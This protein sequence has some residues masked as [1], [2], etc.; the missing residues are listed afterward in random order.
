[1]GQVYRAT[2]T[3]LGR[4]VAVSPELPRRLSACG[5]FV[6]VV[7]RPSGGPIRLAVERLHE[8]SERVAS[9][10]EA[11]RWEKQALENLER[12]TLEPT[13][14]EIRDGMLAIT[15]ELNADAGGLG[16][17]PAPRRRPPTD[18]LIFSLR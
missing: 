16:E 17:P 9:S 15:G 13:A 18:V 1:M 11:T 14:E 3:R 2:D 5:A 6:S 8:L 7:P 10:V 12:I 4:E